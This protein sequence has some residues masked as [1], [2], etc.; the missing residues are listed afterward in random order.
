AV[1]AG[2][3]ESGPGGPIVRVKDGLTLTVPKT[4]LPSGAAVNCLIRPETIHRAASD[5]RGPNRLFATLAS[6]LWLHGRWA[7]ELA[8]AGGVVLRAELAASS[9]EAP[10]VGDLITV[11]IA[12]DDIVVL[13]G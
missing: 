1:L 9:A 6:A 2:R 12:A 3:L 4:N 10:V 8:L 11:L 13:P 7:C 5:A